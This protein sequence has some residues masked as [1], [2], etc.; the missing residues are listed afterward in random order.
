[1]QMCL[2][3]VH[4]YMHVNN[5]SKAKGYTHQLAVY[6]S[7]YATNGPNHFWHTSL[8]YIITFTHLCMCAYYIDTQ[9]HRLPP[10]N[11]QM[12]LLQGWTLDLPHG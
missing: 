9:I 1:M 10:W 6:A 3:Q 5:Q 4:T 8:W 12:I 7:K 2:S 11:P